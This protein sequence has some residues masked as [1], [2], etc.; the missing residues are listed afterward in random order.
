MQEAITEIYRGLDAH[1][2]ACCRT[3]QAASHRLLDVWSDGCH[4]GGQVT[5]LPVI[6][7]FGPDAWSFGL[8]SSRQLLF[9]RLA[10]FASALP[11]TPVR[12]STARKDHWISPGLEALVDTVS[13]SRWTPTAELQFSMLTVGNFGRRLV[14]FPGDTSCVACGVVPG[15][16][17]ED[18]H[19]V[20]RN[21][22][23]V[24]RAA[25][26]STITSGPLGWTQV[27]NRHASAARSRDV[28]VLGGCFSEGRRWLR[29]A[30]SAG[31]VPAD[32][33]AKAL[34]GLARPDVSHQGDCE[35]LC[36]Y[37]ERAW[38]I[39][40]QQDDSHGTAGVPRWTY[41]CRA[42]QGIMMLRRAFREGRRYS[43]VLATHGVKRALSMVWRRSPMTNKITSRP[44]HCT[45]EAL[46]SFQALA[47]QQYG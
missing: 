23:I 26:T 14:D 5:G 3:G 38:I 37:S 34:R 4:L 11:S 36:A 40:G 20:A 16:S 46:T 9:A 17:E 31:D 24:A 35:E 25:G 10:V 29:S 19:C 43:E 41:G 8:L 45:R 44:R 1:W 39:C 33:L 30:W 28:P 42:Q 15:D 22:Q 27:T 13:C 47:D 6:R 21:Q 18:Q 2:W 7:H 12:R 32:I